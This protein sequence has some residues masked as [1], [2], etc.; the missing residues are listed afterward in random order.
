MAGQEPTQ[1][2]ED[3]AAYRTPG[4]K[5]SGRVFDHQAIA[6]FVSYLA[7]SVLIF[8]RSV[9]AHPTTVYIGQGPDTQQ[10]IWFMAWW[11][12]AISHHLN[13]FLTTV[14]WAPSGGNLAWACD[15]PLAACLLYPVTRLWGPV[16]SGNVLH[17][18]APPL[19]GWSTFVLCR[20]L[21]QRYWPAWLGGCIFAFSPFMLASMTDG[22]LF[23]LFFPVPLAVWATLRRLAGELKSRSFLSTMVLLLVAQFLLSVEILASGVLFGAIALWLAARS[24]STDEYTRLRSA[25]WLIVSAYAISAFV[26]SPYL[27]YM[28]AF[29]RPPAFIFPPWR[30]SIDLVNFIVPTNLN[31]LGNIPLFQTIAHRFLATLYDSGGYM[32]LPLLAIVALFARER[33]HDRS[34]RFMVYMFASACM[35][36]MGPFLEILG[37]RLVPL[38]GAALAALPLIDK[39][40]PGRL[41]PYAYL[42][43]AVT[44]ATWLAEKGGRKALRWALGLAI[45]PFMLPNLSASFWAT[46]AEV[47][48]FFSSGL[49][50]KYIAPKQNV[51]ILPYGYFGEGMLWQAITDMYFRMAGGY[52]SAVP[53]V[54]TEHRRWPIMTGLYKDVGVP[55]AGD[56][57]KAY[58]A[59]HDVS[60]IIVGPSSHYL[61]LRIGNQPT[62]ATLVR[63]PTIDR[64]RIATEK[65]LASLDT[66]PL[67]V[68]GI[69][70]Y[71][72]APQTL[73]P[74]R[75]LTALEM[76]RRAARA[77]FEALLL[78]AE[79]YVN[80]GRDPAS[81]SPQLAQKLGLL[82]EDWFGGALSNDTGFDPVFHSSILLGPSKTG[83]VMIGVE[84]PYDALDPIV[85]TYG[86]N[87]TGTYF[88]NP[89]PFSP[90]SVPP[91]E[92][93]M[94]AMTFDRVGLERAAMAVIQRQ[95]ADLHPTPSTRA[96]ER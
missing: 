48:A 21:V 31:Q 96:A 38:P 46:P 80:E 47:P 11:A 60:A 58:L 51:M 7:L 26:L 88:P 30:E 15:F 56:Q 18:V 27:Y 64:E 25:A 20:Y 43:S 1:P 68:G 74:Y 82:P 67:N 93:A 61:V 52:L 90:N 44:I 70:L 4:S 85:Q 37:Y 66:Q 55:E 45:A 78:G 14:A 81:L 87:A 83:G 6:A 50:S 84:G 75:H 53:P 35:L 73:A 28:L 13:P 12:H 9:I 65:L 95:K 77:R 34:G 94:M 71:R 57:L 36:A 3:N 54:P 24:S 29:E 69:T 89:E 79:R 63:W 22:V 42:A 62:P 59:N 17:L 23:V 92:P 41:M 32:G 72:V 39:A 10:Y 2:R 76:Q 16:V 91:R 5:P 19:A 40:Q 86:A 8:G 33:W 49:Y